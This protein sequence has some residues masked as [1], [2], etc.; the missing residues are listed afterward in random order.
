MAKLSVCIESVFGDVPY[1]KRIETIARLGF[2]YYE[3]W[4][5]NKGFTGSAL[6]DEKKDFNMIAEMNEKLGL[7]TVGFVHCHADGGIQ[8]SLL[9]KSHRNKIVD[10]L[11][12]IIPLAKKIKCKNLISGGGNIDPAISDKKA[13]ENIVGNLKAIMPEMEKNGITVLLEPWNTKVDHPQNW[14]WDP[15]LAVR[16]LKAVGSENVKMLYDMYH[17]Q[18]M[19]GNISAFITENVKYIG[20]FHIA[21]VPGR[22]EPLEGNEV[23]YPFIIKQ[24]QKA[25]YKGAFGLEYWPTTDVKISL[26]RCLDHFKG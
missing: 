2:K 1:K 19:T 13:E 18:I 9:N 6:T 16:I 15:A 17:M 24:A 7:T 11:G 12:E 14:L 23:N 3:F 20:H 25:G 22:H 4:F 21:G 5:H 26:K 10:S 8:A